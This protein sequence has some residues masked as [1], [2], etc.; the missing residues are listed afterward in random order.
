MNK[1]QNVDVGVMLKAYPNPSKDRLNI[2]FTLLQ[3]SKATIEIFNV[4][5]QRLAIALDS[6]EM[7]NKAA[8]AE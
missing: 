8:R 1:I 3:D 5:G 7:A 2:E 6:E 4:A